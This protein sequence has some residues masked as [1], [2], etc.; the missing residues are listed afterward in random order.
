MK[1]IDNKIVSINQL[2]KKNLSWEPKVSS[3]T[4]IKLFQDWILKNIVKKTN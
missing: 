2:F 4:G 1:N 3:K